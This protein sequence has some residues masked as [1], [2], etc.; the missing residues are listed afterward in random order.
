MQ[1]FLKKGQKTTGWNRS[2]QMKNT[3]DNAPV[4]R[5]PDVSKIFRTA[6]REAVIL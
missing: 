4:A 6:N 2:F 1:F 5:L 3:N